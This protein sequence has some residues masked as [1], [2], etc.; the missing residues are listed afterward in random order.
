MNKGTKIVLYIALLTAVGMFGQLF[1]SS[2]AAKQA[3]LAGD[4][5]LIHVQIPASG[6]VS[7]NASKPGEAGMGY[8]GAGLIFAIVLLGMLVAHDVSAFVANRAIKTLYDDDTP[9]TGDPEYEQAEQEWANGQHL[10]AIRLMREYLVKRPREQ[11]VAI[12][13]AEIYEKDLNNPLAAAL[14]YEEILTHK[15]SPDRWGWA[16]IHLCNIYSSKLNQH[17]KAVALL[18]RI[19]SEYG[20]TAAADKARKRLAMVDGGGD[21]AA[22]AGGE[23]EESQPGQGQA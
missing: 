16:A 17:D 20:N 19:E 5:D 10:E 7:V 15:L 14:E 9:P 4:T 3:R 11:H 8:Y 18:R 21:E 6:S 23:V 12:R 13:I 2:Y 1:V 22:A